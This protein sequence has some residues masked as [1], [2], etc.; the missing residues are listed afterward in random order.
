M[1]AP[2]GNV[3]VAKLAKGSVI[4]ST[5]L[6]AARQGVALTALSVSEQPMAPTVEVCLVTLRPLYVFSAAETFDTVQ[7]PS[8]GI[9]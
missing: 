7:Q 9:L 8:A 3:G 1:A 4:A 6:L 2:S 5:R